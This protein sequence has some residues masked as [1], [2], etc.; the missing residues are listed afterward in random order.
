[1]DQPTPQDLANAQQIAMGIFVMNVAFELVRA[2][3]RPATLLAEWG[4]RLTGMLASAETP[5]V[6]KPL[7]QQQLST[8]LAALGET[9]VRR[10]GH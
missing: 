7:V 10:Q 2:H 9:V 5:L 3:P 8:W 6:S 4:T 1:M